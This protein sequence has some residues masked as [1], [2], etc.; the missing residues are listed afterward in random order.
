MPVHTRNDIENIALCGE[1]NFNKFCWWPDYPET[2][3]ALGQYRAF[4]RLAEYYF[5]SGDAGAWAVLDN[6]LNW[7]DEYVVTL[8]R[9]NRI[10]YFFWRRLCRRIR[11]FAVRL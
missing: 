6:W 9:Q 2:G 8:S 11:L 10:S 3:H 7:F 1:E 5:V 4:Y